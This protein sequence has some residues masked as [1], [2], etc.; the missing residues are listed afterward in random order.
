MK[1]QLKDPEI[2]VKTLNLDIELP[3]KIES[4]ILFSELA[5]C[6]LGYYLNIIDTERDYKFYYEIIKPAV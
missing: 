1:R 5:Y 3:T 2:I 4:H 6:D